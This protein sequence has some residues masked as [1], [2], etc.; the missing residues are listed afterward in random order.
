M[1]IRDSISKNV[2]SIFANLKVQIIG[3]GVS[4]QVSI[5]GLKKSKHMSI[6]KYQEKYQ[7]RYEKIPST[8]KL[9]LNFR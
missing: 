5:N 7:G 3:E 9:V 6:D 1:E 2:S 4:I 8:L